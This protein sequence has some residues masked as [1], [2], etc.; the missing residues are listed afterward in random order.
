MKQLRSTRRLI[1]ISA[2][3]AGGVLALGVLL[4]IYTSGQPAKRFPAV[5]ANDFSARPTACLAADSNTA[6]KD[7]TT[8]KVWSAMQ[9]EGKASNKNVQQ[10]IMPVGD[11]K[12]AQPYLASLISQR[13]DLIITVGSRFGQAIPTLAKLTPTTRFIAVEPGLPSTP[14]AVTT[15]TNADAPDHIRQQIQALQRVQPGPSATHS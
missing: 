11:A 5:I 13:C 1:V 7:Q 8:S 15:L 2:L 10:L 4:W 3:S 6:T 12:Q 14:I 9:D